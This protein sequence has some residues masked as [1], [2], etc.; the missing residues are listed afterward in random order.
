MASELRTSNSNYNAESFLA[1]MAALLHRDKHLLGSV[2]QRSVLSI[3]RGLEPQHVVTRIDVLPK[4]ADPG[5]ARLLDYGNL[6]FSREVLDQ[7]EL[8]NRF[9]L[10]STNKFRVLEHEISAAGLGFSDRYQPSHSQRSEWPVTVFTISF[11]SP[12][13]LTHEPLLHSELQSFASPFEAIGRFLELPGFTSSSD[14]LLHQ[15]TLNIPNLNARIERLKLSQGDLDMVVGG[16]ASPNSLKVDISYKDSRQAASV[17]RL[18]EGRNTAFKLAFVPTALNLWLISTE[19][20]LADFHEENEHYS[21]GANSVLPKQ[22]VP[23]LLPMIEFDPDT[24]APSV[25][26]RDLNRTVF[27]IHGHNTSIKESVARFLQKLDVEPVILHEQ[28]NRGQTLIEKFEFNSEVSF[29]VALLT[30]D[31]EGRALNGQVDFRRRARQ[32][33]LLELGF[34][35]GKL[36]RERVCAVHRLHPDRR[37]RKLA[38]SSGS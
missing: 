31:D 1:R 3:I 13:Q 6:I 33:V 27:I 29:A 21:S 32:N 8:L 35:I 30:G 4:A 16:P 2:V 20:F 12:A 36:G 26:R 19:G 37:C 7:A 18:L 15:I 11:A 24:L 17:S 23:T 34:F 5:G 10:L 38:V 14:S 25:M 9:Q 22:E 28:P